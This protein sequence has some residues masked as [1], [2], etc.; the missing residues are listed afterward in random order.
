MSITGQLIA[1]Y[2]KAATSRGILNP[3]VGNYF[4]LA[5]S[6]KTSAAIYDSDGVLLR[7]LWSD[8]SYAAGTHP[9]YW[10]GKDDLGNSLPLGN[11]PAKVIAHNIDF[12]WEGVIGACNNSDAP[13]GSSVFHYFAPIA[14]VT[15]I[16]KGGLEY[17]DF[18]I[19]FSE[20]EAGQGRWAITAPR[21]CI[22][23]RPQATGQATTFK[24]SNSSYIFNAG[25]DYEGVNNF[26]FSTNISDDAETQWTAGEPEIP[27][28]GYTY[29]WSLDLNTL[30]SAGAISGMACTTK[31]LFVAHAAQNIINVFLINYLSGSFV[32]SISMTGA[33]NMINEGENSLWVC[34]A[35]TAKKFTINS[36]GTLT[37]AV[38][39]ISSLARPAGIS[40]LSGDLCII[41]GGNQQ[42]VKR[43]NS[44]TG[45]STGTIGTTGGY[46]TSP[47]ITN[48]K[49]YIEDARGVLPTYVRHQSDGSIWVGDTGN[50][51]NLHFAADGSYI[52]NITYLPATYNVY[53]VINQPTNVFAGFLEYLI[54]YSE[55]IATRATLINNWGYSY[56]LTVN[57]HPTI[58]DGQGLFNGIGLFD[59]DRRYGIGS[60]GIYG[61]FIFE[62]TSTGFK[63]IEGSTVPQFS[64]LA[65]DLSL[66]NIVSGDFVKY[67][68][69]GY[70]TDGDGQPYPAWSNTATVLSSPVPG[71]LY[72]STDGSRLF[73]TTD[74]GLQFMY[75]GD[76]GSTQT[77]A[78]AGYDPA[79]ET[80]KS[81]ALRGT[82]TTYRGDFPDEYFDRGNLVIYAGSDFKTIYKY[83]I[84]VYRGENWKQGQ[85]SKFFV[86]HES[87]Q[88][89]GTP[90]VVQA[91]LVPGQ[92]PQPEYSSNILYVIVYHDTVNHKIYWT[93]NGENAHS[94]QS[95]VMTGLNTLQEID[96]TVLL[97]SPPY[98]APVIGV[99]LLAG[100]PEN[101]T[102]P[103]NTNGWTRFPTADNANVTTIT[104]T[105]Q[106]D[107]NK[108]P[109]I[110]INVSGGSGL[111]PLTRSLPYNG[112]KPNWVVSGKIN[113][114][115]SFIGSEGPYEKAYIS[116]E[117]GTGKVILRI[118]LY[119]T[120]RLGV[121]GSF[122]P[123]E[124][125]VIN[126]YPASDMVISKSGS[127]VF[128]SLNIFG[129]EYSNTVNLT[130]PTA[131]INDPATLNFVAD[132]RV[133]TSGF[134]IDTVDLWWIDS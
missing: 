46:A 27:N 53:G 25:K 28:N 52:E 47:T 57:G 100:V 102:L 58:N 35:T 107:L 106:A 127:Q 17:M 36:D 80:Y 60:I 13:Y 59:N 69:T 39:T 125:T 61:L 78:L 74:N 128:W 67:S 51:R 89:I 118:D 97:T 112:S 2:S 21:T 96:V 91:Q 44:T 113:L 63:A 38:L 11:Y 110:N 50:K 109:D 99:D 126:T 23:Y 79:T 77:Y 95:W 108:S 54:D 26:V 66:N 6:A 9:I 94:L 10:D 104:R 42:I 37:A 130:D 76:K 5:G 20:A 85:T 22:N 18:G 33:T 31:Y 133:A 122:Y 56:P 8:V 117:D 14:D 4:T 86:F 3:I 101:S 15:S 87:G 71:S 72:P 121:N 12:T 32:R 134:K 41:D 119:Q 29:N 82:P 55:P 49:F 81:K 68:Q 64:Q 120:G 73:E 116:V 1:I 40:V 123:E 98:I 45:S 103:N 19:P 16:I 90:G 114:T 111:F 115:G 84:A 92:N 48:T 34:Q 105:Q 70:A 124:G 43:Y 129:V 131:N 24:C 65:N 30:G 83:I 62:L 132:Y 7:T 93:I 88:R 75:D